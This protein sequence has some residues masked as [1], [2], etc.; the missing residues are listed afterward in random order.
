[1]TTAW[2]Y[3]TRTLSAEVLKCRR[4]LIFWLAAGAPFFA[5]FLLF[6]IFYFKGHQIIRAD[7]DPNPW[8]TYL[9][10]IEDLWGFFLFP[11]YIVLQSA[12]LLSLEHQSGAWKHLYALAL[13][14]WTVYFGKLA[15]CVGLVTLC[16]CLLY[17]LTEGAGMLLTLLRP[18]LDFGRYDVSP[19][20]LRGYAKLWLAGLGIV[21]IQHYVS[22]RYPNFI[23][24]T[25]F[26]FAMTL[27]AVALAGQP[28]LQYIPYAFP[29]AA[30]KFLKYGSPTFPL[31]DQQVC[32]SLAV[33]VV[34][35]LL[36]YRAIARRDVN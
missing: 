15:L 11:S 25:A 35:S 3:F 21:G 20:I 14:R 17:V 30:L 33:F 24:P 28:A 2:Q 27:A 5:A 22:F 6:N 4:T 1:M 16:V 10:M 31:V 12:L 9:G 13:P 7:G 32:L 18:E 23:V 36:G 8:A 26:G 29:A 19:V 34:V